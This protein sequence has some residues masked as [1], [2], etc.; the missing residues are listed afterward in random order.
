MDEY[1]YT[2]FIQNKILDAIR[3]NYS[4][5]TREIDIILSLLQGKCFNQEIAKHFNIA[6]STVKNHLDNIYKKM[7]IT[8]KSELFSIL[9]TSSFHLFD[10]AKFMFRPPKVLILENNEEKLKNIG[11]YYKKKNCKT[12]CFQNIDNEFYDYVIKERID[13]IICNVNSV[14]TPELFYSKIKANNPSNPAIVFI[15]K[16]EPSGVITIDERCRFASMHMP[17]TVKDLFNKSMHALL[18]TSNYFTYGI[19]TKK[20][21]DVTIYPDLRCSTL[22]IGYSGMFV[23]VQK[24]SD[25]EVEQEIEF[26][27]KIQKFKKIEGQGVICWIR[28]KDED[29][30]PKGLGVRFK[31]LKERNQHIINDFVKSHIITSFL[32]LE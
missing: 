9:L 32:V 19:R 25:F 31:N 1:Y 8:S 12:Y 24:T 10:S 7:N 2:P 28:N 14:D 3:N 29:Q 18:E 27:L 13:L 21:L 16:K 26:S 5:T 11:D 20:K 23:T 4:L 17:F 15:M 22:N 6:A 30:Y